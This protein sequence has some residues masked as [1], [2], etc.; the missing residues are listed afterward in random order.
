M[1]RGNKKKEKTDN[2]G[3]NEFHLNEKIFD[4]KIWKNDEK[5][6][7]NENEKEESVEKKKKCKNSNGGWCK[8]KSAL[9]AGAAPYHLKMR[10]ENKNVKNNFCLENNDI[11]FK[12]ENK[13]VLEKIIER[14]Y[15]ENKMDKN[16]NNGIV[17]NIL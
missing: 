7:E 5:E 4:F 14:I 12:E 2:T 11:L 10:K 1:T 15:K 9:R 13:K 16:E 8:K 17:Y 3:E 6:N